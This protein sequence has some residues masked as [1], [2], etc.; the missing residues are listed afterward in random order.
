MR[1]NSSFSSR[2]NMKN[3]SFLRF[4]RML[5][6]AFRCVNLQRRIARRRGHID[7]A[8]NRRVASRRRKEPVMKR[9]LTWFWTAAVV[10]AAIIAACATERS[11]QGGPQR[12]ATVQIDADDIGG[13]VSGPNGPEARSE[14]RRVGKEWRS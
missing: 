11:N 12:A 3:D 2:L 7:T 13:V 10:V 1:D 9:K 4:C 6:D 14:E 5:V 8:R